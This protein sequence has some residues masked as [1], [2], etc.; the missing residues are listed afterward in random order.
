M[1]KLKGLFF[2]VGENDDEDTSE[3]LRG[4]IEGITRIEPSMDFTLEECELAYVGIPVLVTLLNKNFSTN[5]NKVNITAVDLVTAKTIADIG[6][7][8]DATKALERE[9]GV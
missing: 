3:V 1:D 8:V 2:T 5:K 7:A 9:Q 6:N 4:I